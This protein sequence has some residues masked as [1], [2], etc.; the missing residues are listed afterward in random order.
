MMIPFKG[1]LSIKQY[2]PKKPKPWGESSI[3]WRHVQELKSQGICGTGNRLQ[4][5]QLILKISDPHG[6]YLYPI[7]CVPEMEQERKEDAQHP[8][9][10][11]CEALQSAYGLALE[12][13]G[14]SSLRQSMQTDARVSSAPGHFELQ[15]LSMQNVNGQLETGAC[16]DGPRDVTDR[17]CS[18]DECD[19]YFRVCL[20]EYQL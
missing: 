20:K 17:R 7:R 12:P 5:A 4:G 1:R 10:I 13:A 18:A 9:A 2:I 14:L 19:T 8:K 6:L 11:F 3:L 16:C 15:I